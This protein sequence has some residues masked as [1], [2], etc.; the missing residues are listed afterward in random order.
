MSDNI[1]YIEVSESIKNW[2]E[3]TEMLLV[4]ALGGRAKR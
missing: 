4:H 3:G 2:R 1:E